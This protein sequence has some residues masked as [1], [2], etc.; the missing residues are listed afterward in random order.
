MRIIAF[1]DVHMSAR[2]CRHIP[3]I[4]SADLIIA[5]GDLT[6]YGRKGDA[7]KVLEEL[8]SVN[9]RLLAV[10]GNLDTIEINDYLEQLDLNL[11]G[12]ARLIQGKICLIGA[13]GSNI[14]PFRT[15][16][17]FSEREITEILM[18]GYNQATEYIALA[19]PLHRCKI[20]MILVSHAPPHGTRVDR[21][22]NG[23]HVGS[24]A[25]RSFIEKYQPELCISGHIHEAKGED[26]LGATRILNPGM[27]QQG[28]WVDI[29]LNAS[30]LN[31]I[32]Q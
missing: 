5:T 27:L 23:R 21:L 3:G 6:N 8:L 15:P 26:T 18:R 19:T 31:A 13:G 4:G 12:Q 20:P 25:V 32:L 9:P 10:L 14:T 24:T 30:T 1:G 11:H 16:T 7:K 29:T 22:R 17:E 28:G 2:V